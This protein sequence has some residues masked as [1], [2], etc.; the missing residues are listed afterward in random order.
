MFGNLDNTEIEKVLK[1]QIVAR[2]GCHANNMTYVVPTSYAYDGIYIYGHTQEGMKIEMMRQNPKVCFEVDT[3]ENMANWE[4]VI[5]WGEFEEII[6]LV[7]REKALKKLLERKLPI[8]TSKTV[9]LTP[10][11]PFYS[12]NLNDIQGIVFRIKLT[13]KTGRFEKS[14]EVPFIR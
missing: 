12:G 3:M 13:K 7:E 1:N 2:I 11:W 9:Q 8:V 5:A 4:S 14:D 10:N 6:D